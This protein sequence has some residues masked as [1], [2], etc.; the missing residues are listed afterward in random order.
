MPSVLSGPESRASRVSNAPPATPHRPRVGEILAAIRNGEEGL[1]SVESLDIRS[2]SIN[3]G[4]AESSAQ[5]VAQFEGDQD[6]QL[7]IKEDKRRTVRL[8]WTVGGSA[9]EEKKMKQQAK[10]MLRAF[11]GESDAAIIRSRYDSNA[12]RTAH[13]GVRR[14]Q[15]A[16]V[17]SRRIRLTPATT[18]ME[19]CG[20]H[21]FEHAKLQEEEGQ[22]RIASRSRGQKA[23][24]R[25]QARGGEG[26]LHPPLPSKARAETA[27]PQVT[28][29]NTTSSRARDALGVD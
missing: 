21:W 20:A 16:E 15:Q 27:Q 24:D 5:Y 14:H 17:R 26:G 8:K 29:N 4:T 2:A 6:E 9:A 12:A 7:L 3:R 1:E 11:N 18:I 22:K 10:L 28:S 13:E 19:A 25:R 23:G